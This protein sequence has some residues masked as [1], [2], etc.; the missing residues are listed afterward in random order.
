MYILSGWI[1]SETADELVFRAESVLNGVPIRLKTGNYRI[2]SRRPDGWATIS[3]P[4]YFVD[5]ALRERG[6]GKVEL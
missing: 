4:E 1:E 6:E 3:V 5:K 2:S